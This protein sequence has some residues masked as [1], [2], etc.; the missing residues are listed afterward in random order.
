MNL[1][2]QTLS[3]QEAPGQLMIKDVSDIPEEVEERTLIRTS[4]LHHLLG[5][6]ICGTFVQVLARAFCVD[7]AFA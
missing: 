3:L 6:T 2:S 5:T 7:H 4:A 1:H